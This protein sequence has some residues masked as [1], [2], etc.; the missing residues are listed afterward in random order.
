MFAQRVEAVGRKWVYDRWT[1]E[2]GLRNY[3]GDVRVREFT[4]IIQVSSFVFQLIQFFDDF[5]LGEDPSPFQRSGHDLERLIALH[6][7]VG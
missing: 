7:G 6:I 3:V 5:T 1:T 2:R 4:T